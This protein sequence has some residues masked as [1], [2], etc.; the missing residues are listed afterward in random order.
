MR[1]AATNI[2]A[3]KR[4]RKKDFWPYVFSGPVQTVYAPL[5]GLSTVAWII[6]KLDF[7]ILSLLPP[8]ITLNGYFL[9]HEELPGFLIVHIDL[10][11]IAA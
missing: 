5:R 8:F 7:K 3:E 9:T 4:T 2:R 1:N 11:R 6:I 10:S